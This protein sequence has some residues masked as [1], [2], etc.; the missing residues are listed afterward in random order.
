MLREL[1]QRI[2]DVL[3]GPDALF[4]LLTKEDRAALLRIEPVNQEAQ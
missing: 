4:Y 1:H 2:R 3:Q